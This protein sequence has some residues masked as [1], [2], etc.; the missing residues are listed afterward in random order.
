M[1][2]PAYFRDN[3]AEKP[4]YK[5]TTAAGEKLLARVNYMPVTA[6]EI[7]RK[8]EQELIMNHRRPEDEERCPICFCDLF[9][10]DLLKKELADVE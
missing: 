3:I 9:E 7:Y 1:K 2:K 5:P 6:D 10:N 8:L 4:W